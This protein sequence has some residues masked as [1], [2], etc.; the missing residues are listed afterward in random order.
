MMHTLP[1]LSQRPHSLFR[2]LEKC[3]DLVPVLRG[4]RDQDDPLDAD[5]ARKPF[6]VDEVASSLVCAL[7]RRAR[8]LH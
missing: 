7:D 6:V 5:Q 4:S 2:T 1:I 3:L 8:W